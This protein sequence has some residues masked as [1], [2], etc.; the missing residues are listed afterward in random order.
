MRTSKLAPVSVAYEYHRIS[1]RIFTTT[2]FHKY[3]DISENTVP[4]QLY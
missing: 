4:I 1:P 2:T 3:D